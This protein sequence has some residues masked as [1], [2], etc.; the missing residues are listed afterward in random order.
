MKTLLSLIVLLCLSMVGTTVFAQEGS[1]TCIPTE[2][3]TQQANDLFKSVVTST[4]TDDVSRYTVAY[5]IAEDS[6]SSAS[7]LSEESITRAS[8]S[9]NVV[10]SW[11]DFVALNTETPVDVVF[12]HDSIAPS[13]DQEWLQAAY[14]NGLPIVTLNMTFGE[15]AE[16]I[17][18]HCSFAEFPSDG[19]LNNK[20]ARISGGDYYIYSYWL[21]QSGNAAAA[22]QAEL[23]TCSAEGV[24]GYDTSTVAGMG[25]VSNGDDLDDLVELVL[26]ANQ[27][28][29][30]KAL[31]NVKPQVAQIMNASCRPP[32]DTVE[33]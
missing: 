22:V 25:V 3:A 6:A 18:D 15:R 20:P 14:R 21:L 2:V 26:L 7:L 16:L 13:V 5:L 12:I 28:E 10:T 27:V 17:G 23:N 31:D 8:S 33:D 9:I 4:R 1:S 29:I 11:D 24:G 19:P 30:R 32:V